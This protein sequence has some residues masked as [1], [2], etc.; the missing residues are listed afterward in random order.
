MDAEMTGSWA[1]I[2]LTINLITIVTVGYKIVRFIARVEFKLDILWSDYVSK[3]KLN[4]RLL[5][6]IEE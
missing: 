4:D 1:V 2:I 5:V 6:G 3:K